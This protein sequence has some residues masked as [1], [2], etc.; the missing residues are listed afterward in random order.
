MANTKFYSSDDINPVTSRARVTN[1][2]VPPFSYSGSIDTGI[3]GFYSPPQKIRLTMGY[4]SASTTG[5]ASAA[6]AFIK[7]SDYQDDELLGVIY[8]PATEVKAIWYAD[9]AITSKIISPYETLF[10]ASF[11]ASRHEN[12]TLQL[13]GERVS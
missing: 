13:Y 7:K 8:L 9:N 1:V 2:T 5:N 6:L 11:T 4:M 12:V 3:S 10:V